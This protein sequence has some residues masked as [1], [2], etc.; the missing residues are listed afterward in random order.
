MKPQ[1]SGPADALSADPHL[2]FHHAF[3]WPAGT[4]AGHGAILDSVKPPRVLL[5]DVFGTLVDWRS[6]LL[7]IA[8]TTAA[9]AGVHASWAAVIDDWRRAYQPIMDEVRGGGREWRD[10]D[11]LQRETL[12]AVLA[13]HA[14]DLPAGSQ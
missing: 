5:F 14:I 8:V 6:S 2:A 10:L 7:N 1:V 13:R 3:G 9:A 12:A 11:S 4:A